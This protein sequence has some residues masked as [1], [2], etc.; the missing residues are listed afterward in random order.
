GIVRDIGEIGHPVGIDKA[1]NV[2]GYGVGPR[3]THDEEKQREQRR[4][5]SHTLSNF[6]YHRD[7]R[8]AMNGLAVNSPCTS[9]LNLSV[10]GLTPF[11]R[12]VYNGAVFPLCS[13]SVA[14]LC[15]AMPKGVCYRTPQCGWN[16]LPSEASSS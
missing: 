7:P 11:D 14:R 10:I 12:S 4:K 3:T 15:V 6:P 8:I 16:C 9:C 2:L 5:A 13:H 1:I